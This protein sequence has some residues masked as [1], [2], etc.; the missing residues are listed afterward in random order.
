MMPDNRKLLEDRPI[1]RMQNTSVEAPKGPI[2]VPI[3][4][5][6]ITTTNK[7]GVFVQ[8]E[9]VERRGPTRKYTHLKGT[10]E[11]TIVL[12]TLPK[13]GK[14]DAEPYSFVTRHHGGKIACAHCGQAVLMRA[15]RLEDDK[16]TC[17]CER[18]GHSGTFNKTTLRMAVGHAG[19]S[20][21]FAP[22]A[23]RDFNTMGDEHRLRL[24]QLSQG[25]R[26]SVTGLGSIMGIHVHND[27]G[28][29]LKTCTNQKEDSDLRRLLRFEMMEQGF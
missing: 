28:K 27:E 16:T 3:R 6:M 9:E 5:Q 21:L 24:Q 18:T 23:S 1:R 13:E 19:L 12:L 8:K 26:V 7:G 2:R 4:L 15:A 11:P 25:T 10:P 22:Q 14:S 29:V 20:K 17:D